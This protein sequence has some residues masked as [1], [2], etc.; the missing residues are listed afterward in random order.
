FEELRAA[1]AVVRYFRRENLLLPSRPLRGPAPHGVLWRPARTSAILSILKNPA[2]AG[3]YVYGRQTLD[4]ARRKPG[5]P[6]TGRVTRPIDRCPIVIHNHY[7]AYI[8]W[9]EFLANQAQ[10]EA[11]Q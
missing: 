1:R 11:N 2:Y 10:F 6:K 9:E 5:H 7:P 4:P 3:A 8:T